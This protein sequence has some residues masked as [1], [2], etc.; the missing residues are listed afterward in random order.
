MLTGELTDRRSYMLIAETA[1]AYIFLLADQKQLQ[2]VRET[3]DA[4]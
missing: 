2:L 1:N 3:C 4:Q